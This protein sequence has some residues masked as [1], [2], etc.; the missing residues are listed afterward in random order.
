MTIQF[1]WK[2]KRS[3]DKLTGNEFQALLSIFAEEIQR[4]F[5]TAPQNKR[6]CGRTVSQRAGGA[7]SRREIHE[8]LSN[9]SKILRS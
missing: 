9:L 2:Q 4:D 1:V 8:N 5:V 6:V 3:Y 7:K